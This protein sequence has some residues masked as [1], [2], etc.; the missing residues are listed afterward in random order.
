MKEVTLTIEDNKFET[1][2]EFMKT[3]NYVKVSKNEFTV[4]DFQ[5]SLKEVKLMQSGKLPKRPIEKLLNEL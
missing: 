3:L 5:R 2:I 4:R 1:F